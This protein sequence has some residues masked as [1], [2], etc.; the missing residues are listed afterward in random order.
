[1]A[2][3]ATHAAE[4]S[5]APAMTHATHAATPAASPSAS[6][7]PAPARID[8]YRLRTDFPIL[9]T[10][11]RFGKPLI[12]LDS[13]ATSLKPR[14]VIDAVDA[15]RAA[16]VEAAGVRAV[17]TDTMMRSPEIAAALAAETLAAVA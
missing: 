1:M 9:A 15:D 12:Y 2:D 10:A 13:A 17:V 8:P 5:P 6:A 16:E 4:S 7:R 14:A 3:T 11:N